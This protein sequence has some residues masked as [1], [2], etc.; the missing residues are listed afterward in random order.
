MGIFGIFI[1]LSELGK[2]YMSDA[3]RLYYCVTKAIVASSAFSFR[4]LSVNIPEPGDGTG[5]IV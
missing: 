2:V 3:F 1:K 4:R 5:R